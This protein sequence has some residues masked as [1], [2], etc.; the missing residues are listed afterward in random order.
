VSGTFESVSRFSGV[1]GSS[2]WVPSMGGTF[3]KVHMHGWHVPHCLIVRSRSAAGILKTLVV[4][5]VAESDTFDPVSI[6]G[7]HGCHVHRCTI[8]MQCGTWHP[9][10]AGRELRPGKP[11][12]GKTDLRS[13]R[14]IKSGTSLL[15]P[16][17]VP[18]R[19]AAVSHRCNGWH[20]CLEP[21]CLPSFSLR[22]ATPLTSCERI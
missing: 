11:S 8:V 4:A 20:P 2:S 18:G 17:W 7:S 22:T 13:H 6:T 19:R 9:R 10:G 16:K 21:A 3:R 14:Q 1:Q 5:D 12:L 15:T